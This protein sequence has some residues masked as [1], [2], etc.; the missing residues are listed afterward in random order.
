MKILVVGNGGREH[1]LAW[2]IS[3]DPRNPQI[4]CMPGNAGTASLGTNVAVAADDISSILAWCKTEQPDMTIVGPEAPLCAGLVDVLEREGLRVFG[5]NKAAAQ[6]E[7]SKVFAKEI[8]ESSGVPTA[9]SAS[10]SDAGKA[11]AYVRQEGAPIVVKAEGLAAGKGVT[12][13]ESIEQAERAIDEA[14]CARVFGAA[15]EKVLIEECLVGQEASILALVDGKTCVLLASSQDHKRAHEGDQ[16]PNTGGMGAYSPAPIVTDAL[17]PVIREQVFGRT[18]AGLQERGITFKGVLYA[19]LMLTASGPKVL[20]FN[21][22][23]GDPETQVILP[24]LQSDILPLFDACIDGTLSTA[25]L[26]WD[27]SSCVT[28]VMAS[29]GYPG[30][31][32]KGMAITGLDE[33]SALD[34]VTVFHAGTVIQDQTVVTAG[35]RVLAVTALGVTLPEAISRSYAGVDKIAFSGGWCRRDIASKA[36]DVKGDG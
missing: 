4:F 17:W 9:R 11:K 13:C 36:L 25:K 35:G 7:G 21:T 20:E 10:F 24:R 29:S 22:R 6:L 14:M 23:F 28:V 33:A 15:G 27:P 16:G 31:Y 3:Q 12:V 2:K 18:L 8:M 19:G 5:P 30:T 1:A 26:A 34:H 32:T